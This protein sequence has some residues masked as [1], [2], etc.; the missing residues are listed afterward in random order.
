MNKTKFVK[1]IISSVFAVATIAAITLSASASVTYN[2]YDTSTLGATAY[3]V[4]YTAGWD[5]STV[6]NRNIDG[7]TQIS[8]DKSSGTKKFIST[9]ACICAG[10]TKT[11]SRFKNTVFNKPTSGPTN[12]GLLV[13]GIG[14]NYYYS[15]N[16]AIESYSESTSSTYQIESSYG[17]ITTSN[18]LTAYGTIEYR[19]STDTIYEYLTNTNY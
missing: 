5:A 12:N 3:N 4:K 17:F 13:V 1:R 11:T 15:G 9:Y 18:P 19:N 10:G 7:Y 2:L 6:I 14:A 16:T 8:R